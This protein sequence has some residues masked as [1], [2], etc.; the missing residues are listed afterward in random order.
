MFSQVGAKLIF[1][2]NIYEQSSNS[3]YCSLSSDKEIDS[4]QKRQYVSD[5]KWSD[6]FDPLFLNNLLK[7]MPYYFNLIYESIEIHHS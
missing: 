7:D 1:Y 4:W 3:E 5:L 6:S 2:R